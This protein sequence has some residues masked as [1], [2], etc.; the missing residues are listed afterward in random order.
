VVEFNGLTQGLVAPDGN[1]GF[2][3]TFQTLSG[4]NYQIWYSDDLNGPWNQASSIFSAT[5]DSE[6]YIW[7]DDGS[8]TSPSPSTVNRRF[9]KIEISRP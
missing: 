5:S 4:R 8:Q 6:A 3:I 7:N 1:G 9:Y 2:N